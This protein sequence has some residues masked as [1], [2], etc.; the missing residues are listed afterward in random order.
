M[1]EQ[2][3][4]FATHRRWIPMWHFFALPVLLINVFVVGYQFVRSPQL[5]T[6]WAVLVA[7]ALALGI[8]VSRTMPLRA[9]DRII[10][11]EERTRLER[12]LPSDLRGRI[13]ELTAAQ[14][15]AIRFASDEDVPDLT[16]RT[17]NGELKSTGDIKRAI[18]NWRADTLR[19]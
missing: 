17:L 10:R 9:Q 7:L 6:G 18:R 4:T 1:A 13:G 2:V 11:L 15:V 16:R 12:V 5:V 3:Q 19:V 8:F 14:L